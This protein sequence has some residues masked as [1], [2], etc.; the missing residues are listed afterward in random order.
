MRVSSHTVASHIVRQ[1]QELSNKQLQLQNQVATGQRITQ[2]SDDPA[3]AGRV[4]NHQSAGRRAEQFIRNAGRA[5]ELSQA[6]YSNLTQIKNVLDRATELGTLGQGASSP[7]S[8]TAYATE[9]DQLLEQLVQLGNAKLGNDQLFAGTALDTPP[10]AATRD[11]D[12]RVTAVTYGGNME[13]LPIALSDSAGLS[14]LASGATNL[15]IGDL[16]N[17][18]VALRD[19]LN[20]G[21]SPALS[22]TQ[23]QL[24]DGEDLVIAS[25]A[26]HGAVQMRIEINR[27]QQEALVDNLYALV[28]EETAADLPETIVRLNRAQTAYQAALQSASGIMQISLLDYIK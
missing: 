27:T 7:E 1:L 14:P 24:I 12:N 10:F 4:L 5:L 9:V 13:R 17:R 19:A 26:E 16:M 8:R 18:L 11:G 25:L 3:A 6:S 2:V 22:A 23:R 15:A 21:D 28:S 20:S